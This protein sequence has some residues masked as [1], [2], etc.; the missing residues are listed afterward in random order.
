MNWK[1]YISALAMALAL[2]GCSNILE[3]IGFGP[4]Y[5]PHGVPYHENSVNSLAKGRQF[6]AEGR[7]E[8]ARETFLQG[9]ATA[10][11]KDL[12]ARLADEIEATDRLILS[13]R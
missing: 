8:L 7:Y 5:E 4:N 3:T 6:Q 9:L 13:K 10:R 1:L 2:S 12:R 11:D